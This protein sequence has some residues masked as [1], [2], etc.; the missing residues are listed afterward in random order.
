MFFCLIFS[1]RAVMTENQE[2]AAEFQPHVMP[3]AAFGA[4]VG[5]AQRGI[6]D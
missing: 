6:T 3:Q 4:A 1:P 5:A 2:P